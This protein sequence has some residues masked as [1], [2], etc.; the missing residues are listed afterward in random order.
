MRPYLQENI[1]TSRLETQIEFFIVTLTDFKEWLK[2]GDDT[3]E[4]NSLMA[5]LT[6][7][8]KQAELSTRRTLH[9]GT[10]RTYMEYFPSCLQLDIHPIDTATIVIKYYDSSNVFQTLSATEYFIKNNGPDDWVEI[11][12]Y[13]TMPNV[14]DRYEPIYVEY[15]AG[16]TL[17][18]LPEGIKLGIMEE[19]TNWI[20]SRG[21]PE[22]V[23]VKALQYWFPYKML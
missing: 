20:E 4:D 18:E 6:A 12:F 15:N 7:A 21:N 13:G 10:W 22:Q 1:V 16:Y 19:A 9:K 14:Y 11:L 2:W 5:A 17:G 3:S 23:G 8:S